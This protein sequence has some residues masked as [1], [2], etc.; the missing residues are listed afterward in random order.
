MQYADLHI[1]SCYSDG[2][3][4]PEGILKI[5]KDNNVKYISITDHDNI[6]AQKVLQ[7]T[8]CNFGVE[9]IPGVELS[10]EYE[11]YEV[12]ILGYFI[13]INNLFLNRLLDHI[14]EVRMNRILEIL[15]K[16]QKMGVDITVND[17]EM[18]NNF[19]SI[20]RAHIA[21]ILVDKGYSSSFKGA[22]HN[23]LAK[24][25]SAYVDRSK[26]PYKD[27]LKI[28]KDCGGI[29][30][31]AHPGK[32]YKGI[33]T[34]KLIKDLKVYGLMGIEVFHPSHNINQ[35]SQFYNLSKKYNLAITGGSDFHC[36][37]SNNNINIGSCG[38]S[39]DLLN[40]FIK[41]N[42]LGEIK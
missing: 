30:V 6:S 10:T 13:D 34:D 39:Q 31:L 5:A 17:L 22:F 38:L 8:F 28:V 18:N 33:F 25:K 24:D 9:I 7:S 21:K 20:G 14:K 36:I 41:Y 42:K 27:V 29:P 23:Y 15:S 3:I 40:K 2:N 37:N 11:G 16:L 1:H 19:Q 12:H 32:T 4:S 35:V 26:V